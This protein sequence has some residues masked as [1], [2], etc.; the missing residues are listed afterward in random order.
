VGQHAAV[1]NHTGKSAR[2]NQFLSDCKSL[3]NVP[4]VDALIKYVCPYT[5]TPYLLVIRNALYIPSMENNLIPPFVMREAGLVVND[6]PKIHIS[7]PS[8]SDHSIYC[9]EEDLRIP[10]QLDGIFSFFPTTLPTPDDIQ[11]CDNV[12]ILTPEYNWNPHSDVY[13]WNEGNMLDWEGNMIQKHHRTRIMLSDVLEDN[14]M[15]I[16]SMISSTESNLIDEN[17]SRTSETNPCQNPSIYDLVSLSALITD[18]GELGRYQMAV[19]ATFAT[20]EKYL[21]EMEVNNNTPASYMLQNVEDPEFLKALEMSDDYLDDFMV[22]ATHAEPPKG[23]DAET[24]SKVWSIDI[25]TAERTLKVT[26]Q[27]CNHSEDTTL[28]RNCSTNDRML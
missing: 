1:I 12:I 28:S 23:V 22:S 8:V 14:E 7:D 5:D 6:T 15:N 4:I 17:F 11:N 18:R 13:S 9:A 24:L 2:V 25:P 10:L 21:M 3:D 16:S 19:G 26:S 20:T 27:R